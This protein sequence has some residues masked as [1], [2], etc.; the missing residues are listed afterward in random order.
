MTKFSDNAKLLL[1]NYA[2]VEK[3]LFAAVMMFFI[4][5]ISSVSY[6]M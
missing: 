3:S 6:N 1:I 5:D 4:S 2:F